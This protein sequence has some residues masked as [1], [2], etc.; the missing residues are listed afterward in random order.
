M[1]FHNFHI[2]FGDAHFKYAQR[3]DELFWNIKNIKASKFSI[4]IFQQFYYMKNKIISTIQFLIKY[5]KFQLKN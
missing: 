3:Y 5:I 2:I 1:L 4:S